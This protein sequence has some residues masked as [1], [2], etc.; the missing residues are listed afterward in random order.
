M[1][2]LSVILPILQ[3][4]PLAAQ[5]PPQDH[6]RAAA[7][8]KE[9]TESSCLSLEEEIDEFYFK[10]DNPKAPLIELSDIEGKPD[11]N[12]TI[13]IPPLVIACPDD[14]SDEEV[15]NMVSNKG[16][17]SLR[18]LM[19]ARGKGTTSK[20]PTKSQAPSNLPPAPL[21]VPANLGLKVNPDLKKKRPVESLE[22]GKV[23]PRHGTKQQ[24]VT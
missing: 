2:L 18:E 16:N 6:P 14:S 11:R 10:E 20:V 9:E 17:K 13:C 8:V 4:P 19:A 23:G 3:N 12:F 1:D 5:L 15:G 7:S 21:Q 24:K 22:E